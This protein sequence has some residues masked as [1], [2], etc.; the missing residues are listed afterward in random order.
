MWGIACATALM[1]RR[2]RQRPS[3]STHHMRESLVALIGL[4][5]V[6]PLAPNAIARDNAARPAIAEDIETR[7]EGRFLV[8]TS[9]EGTYVVYQKVDGAT[10]VLRGRDVVCMM[11]NCYAA[12]DTVP[13]AVVEGLS[14]DRDHA[15]KVRQRFKADRD[16]YE[17]V[18]KASAAN[19]A[20]AEQAW[21]AELLKVGPCMKDKNA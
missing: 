13:S 8:T 20:S 16:A 14:Q 1:L 7:F 2:P 15:E 19:K 4:S 10:D 5:L 21:R 18:L 3:L 9:G 6:L 17:G 12:I 11:N